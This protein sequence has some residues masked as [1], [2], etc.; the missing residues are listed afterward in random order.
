MVAEEAMVLKDLA[1]FVICVFAFSAVL[2]SFLMDG[3]EG[4]LDLFATIIDFICMALEVWEDF[5]EFEFDNEQE[6]AQYI[7]SWFKKKFHFDCDEELE[8]EKEE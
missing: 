2:V 5:L 1:I 7:I 3:I 8:E 4:V 6:I